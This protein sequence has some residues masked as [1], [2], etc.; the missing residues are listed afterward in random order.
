MRQIKAFCQTMDQCVSHSRCYAKA[1][2]YNVWRGEERFGR[3]V[4]GGRG[5][6]TG[7]F[8][9]QEARP[10]GEQGHGQGLQIKLGQDREGVGGHYIGQEERLIRDLNDS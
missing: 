4:R 5:G 8:V 10:S 1:S 3:R 2:K 6:R 7:Q 9:G